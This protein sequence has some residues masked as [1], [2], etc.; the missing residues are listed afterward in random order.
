VYQ[1]HDVYTKNKT[2]KKRMGAFLSVKTTKIK[3]EN[4]MGSNGRQIQ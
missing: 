2:G 1:S 4:M 3:I